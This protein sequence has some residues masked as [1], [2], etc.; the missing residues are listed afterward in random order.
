MPF[1]V[2]DVEYDT[3][4]EMQAAI[5][6]LQEQYDAFWEE[7][8]AKAEADRPLSAEELLAAL[9]QQTDVAD[10]LPDEVVAKMG[11]YFPVWDSTATYAVGDKVSWLGKVWRCLIAHTAQETWTPDASPSLWAKV[12]VPDPEAIPEWEQPDSTNPY[13]RGD[14]VHHVNKVWVSDVDNNVWEPGVFG[15]SEAA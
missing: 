2:N 9:V 12:L 15:W 5:D 4:E 3:I 6:E 7:E 11:P 1:I 14:K 8:D 13:M 10:S